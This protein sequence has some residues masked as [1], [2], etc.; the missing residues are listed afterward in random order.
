MRVVVINHVTLDGVMQAPG[1]PDL[2][3]LG[4]IVQTLR[5]HALVEEHVLLIRPLEPASG[6]R[7]YATGGELG[8]GGGND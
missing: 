5:R 1:H 3:V 2:E 6:R 4:R 8:D 7:T